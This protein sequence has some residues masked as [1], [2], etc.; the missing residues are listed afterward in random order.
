MN[1]DK[2][3]LWYLT[4][5]D[6]NRAVSLEHGNSLGYAHVLDMG[7]HHTGEPICNGCRRLATLIDRAC[8]YA[9]VTIPEEE[10]IGLK[11]NARLII[12]SEACRFP[13]PTLAPLVFFNPRAYDTHTH[14]MSSVCTVGQHNWLDRFLRM[15]R[16]DHIDRE[17]NG[18]WQINTR[19][20]L[21]TTY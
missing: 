5:C 9:D 7:G 1:S 17:G 21:D 10:R 6:Y 16:F 3:A 14:A 19:P 13:G 18:V 8:V 11:G 15:N 12:P 4:Y 20:G 2:L